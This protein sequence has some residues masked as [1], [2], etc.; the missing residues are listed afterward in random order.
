MEEKKV[1][2]LAPWVTLYHKLDELFAGDPKVMV[3]NSFMENRSTNIKIYVNGDKKVAALKKLI[4]DHFQFGNVTANISIIPANN[5]E[6]DDFCQL[7]RD[8]FKGN[9]AVKEIYTVESPLKIR[10]TYVIFKKEVVQFFNDDVSDAHGNC[11]TL[12]QEIAKD[13][14]NPC[15]GIMF[16]TDNEDKTEKPLGEWP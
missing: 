12:Y 3:T 1:G 4:P 10:A 14:F 16:C 7:F 2:L 8:A 9:E 13:I 15:P 5:L 6:E 11:S